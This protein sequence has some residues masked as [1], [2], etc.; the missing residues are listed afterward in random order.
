[1]KSFLYIALLI[2]AFC[3]T[4]CLLA[5][6]PTIPNDKDPVQAIMHMAAIFPKNTTRT[7]SG[8][9]YTITKVS[10]DVETTNPI[11]GHLNFTENHED[12]ETNS[13]F[14]LNLQYVFQWKNG[15]WKFTSMICRNTGKDFTYTNGGTEIMTGGSMK[16]FLDRYK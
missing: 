14:E 7:S 12:L 4:N 2:F 8:R 6:Q 15:G 16:S 11:I 10:Y 9:E 1:M 5:E 13:N 3:P